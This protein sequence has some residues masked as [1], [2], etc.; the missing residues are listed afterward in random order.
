MLVERTVTFSQHERSQPAWERHVVSTY[1]DGQIVEQKDLRTFTYHK[2]IAGGEHTDVCNCDRRTQW[3]NGNQWQMTCQRQGRH[4]TPV[5]TKSVLVTTKQE[6]A[7]H[8]GGA[9]IRDV[10]GS[11]HELFWGEDKNTQITMVN[12]WK[13]AVLAQE[14]P[15]VFYIRPKP[16]SRKASRGCC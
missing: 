4:L 9:A 14:L 10:V 2:K 1:S 3:F 5:I 15:L 13:F 16:R 8:V 6:F 7:D 12:E 11:D